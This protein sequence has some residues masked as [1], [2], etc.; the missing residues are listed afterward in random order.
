VPRRD[1]RFADPFRTSRRAFFTRTAS[2]FPQLAHQAYHELITKMHPPHPGEVLKA[3]CLSP[4]NLTVTA[5]ARSLGVSRNT[6]SSILN[7][8]AGPASI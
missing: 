7:A 3:L 5:T 1:F 4:L 8:R 6:L 2:T